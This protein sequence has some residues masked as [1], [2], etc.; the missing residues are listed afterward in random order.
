[1]IFLVK[2]I[3]TI[4]ATYTEF[5]LEITERLFQCLKLGL[6]PPKEKLSCLSHSKASITRFS[7]VFIYFVILLHTDG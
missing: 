3:Y 5:Q 1:M 2:C 7:F 4:S 6:K